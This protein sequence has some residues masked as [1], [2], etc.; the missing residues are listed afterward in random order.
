MRLFMQKTVKQSAVYLHNTI[1]DLGYKYHLVCTRWAIF[2]AE[3][4]TLLYLMEIIQ[5]KFC[6]PNYFYFVLVE[7]MVRL[8]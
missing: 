2:W 4:I 6:P 5:K 1:S 8:P 7:R 3:S